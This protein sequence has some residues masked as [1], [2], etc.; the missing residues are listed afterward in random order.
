MP[1]RSPVHTGAKPVGKGL[2]RDEGT[3]GYSRDATRGGDM[4]KLRLDP[5]NILP[6]EY[7]EVTYSAY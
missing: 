2:A 7:I 3:L 1:P 5:S 4:V 6:I